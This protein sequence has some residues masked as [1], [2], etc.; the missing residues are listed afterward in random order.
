MPL[1]GGPANK[2]GNRYEAYWTIH[3]LLRVLAGEATS[4]RIEPLGVDKAEFVLTVGETRE[5][6]Q[7]KRSQPD[8]SWTLARLRRAGLLKPVFDLLADSGARF[9]FASGSDAPH[10]REL[11]KAAGRT[12]SQAQFEQYFL[13]AETRSKP[14]Q[15]LLTE[16]QCDAST[17]RDCLQR[18]RVETISEAALREKIA[19]RTQPLFADT[20]VPRIMDALRTIVDDSV[21]ATIDERSLLG[22]LAKRGLSLRPSA[23][24]RTARRSVQAATDRYL[25]DARRKLILGRVLRRPSTLELVDQLQRSEQ[26]SHWTITG[27]AGVGKTA[28]VVDI[29]QQLRESGLSVLAFRMDRIADTSNMSELATYLDLGADSPALALHAAVRGTSRPSVL[30]ID[31]L[32]ALSSASGRTADAFD[33][34]ECLLRE[35]RSL[36]SD[37]HVHTIIVCRE[38]DLAN[39]PALRSLVD[40]SASKLVVE[41][42]EPEEVDGILAKV[43]IEP[44]RLDPR[45]RKLLTMPLNLALFLEITKQGST[46]SRFFTAKELFDKYWNVKRRAVSQRRDV[47]TDQW[48]QAM[49]LLVDL[50][51]TTQRLAVAEAHL[52]KIEPAYLDGLVSEGVLIH[53]QATLSFGHESLL[54]YA[55]ARL[56]VRRS[57]TLAASLKESNQGLFR[58][59]QVR[60]TLSYVRDAD[61]ERYVAELRELL[62][63][64]DVRAHIKD[65]ALSWLADVLDPHDGEWLVWEERIGPILTSYERDVSPE[66]KLARLAW[67]RFL[68]SEQWLAYAD[69]HGLVDRWLGWKNQRVLDDLIP[70]MS[71]DQE[72]FGKRLGALVAEPPDEGREGGLG[73]HGVIALGSEGMNRDTFDGL[74][75]HIDAVEVTDLGGAHGVARLLR[76]FWHMLGGRR[77]EWMAELVAAVV[78]CA[79]RMVRDAEGHEPSSLLLG[80]GLGEHDAVEEAAQSA[81]KAFAQF[82]LPPVLELSELAADGT[83]RPRRDKIWLA[84]PSGESDSLFVTDAVV[85][86]LANALSAWAADEPVPGEILDDLRHRDTGISNHMLLAVYRG[87]PKR[88]SAAAIKTFIEEPWRF[89]CGTISSSRWFARETISAICPHCAPGELKLLEDAISRHVPEWERS[90]TGFRSR[91]RAEFDLLTSIPKGL[92][93]RGAD[94]RIGELERK[95]GEPSDPPMD[96]GGGMV[97]SPIPPAAAD[98]MTD[99]QW[100]RAMN[101]HSRSGQI[102]LGKGGEVKGGARQL[103]SELER[104]TKEDPIRF[105]RLAARLPETAHPAYQLAILRGLATTEQAVPDE[106][107]VAVCRGAYE[108]GREDLQVGCAVADVL[109]GLVDPVTDDTVEMLSWLATRHPHLE[110]PIIREEGKEGGELSADPIHG[111]HMWG[112]NTARGRAAEA[113]AKLILRDAANIGKFESVIDEVLL[114]RHPG[115]VSCF[116]AVIV[117]VSYHEPERGMR[118][119][120]RVQHGEGLVF[121][122][123]HFL[124][125]LQAQLPERFGRVRALVTTMIRS[126]AAHAQRA[127]AQLA[128]LAVLYQ[129]EAGDLVAEAIRGTASHRLGIARVASGNLSGSDYRDWC[130]EHLTILFDD[131]DE[132]VRRRAAS[133]FR[134]LHEHGLETYGE[135]IETFV[136]S[137]AFVEGGAKA[138]LRVLVRS[139]SRLPG[140]TCTVCDRFLDLYGDRA[141]DIRTGSAGAA[142]DAR[143]LVFRTYQQHQ[144]DEWGEKAL[145]LIDRL[146]LDEVWGLKQQFEEFER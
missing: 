6:H 107:K 52:D 68:A 137:R 12:V 120:L 26:A 82:V 60:Q 75:R 28:S 45:Q 80:G 142:M 146:C 121:A 145:D 77:P 25:Q 133:C 94:A 73:P 51:T 140:V 63:D 127:G 46:P 85:T 84:V 106:L 130:E 114:D 83:D 104:H 92:R 115:V 123:P 64:P 66:N 56:S 122:T 132:R 65:L 117:A 9:V 95:F 37:P 59:A 108:N 22:Q 103:S 126:S 55:F 53:D 128:A 62:G 33:L 16:W 113:V 10:L 44:G 39:D 14:F 96:I 24:P 141:G 23:N 118:L 36:P 35:V 8:G 57:T 138:I 20:D 30:V 3:E 47:R 87:D 1:P 29:V 48:L 2:L 4:I 40:S 143:K 27:K 32:D 41:E 124:R 129:N 78:R 135:L 11:A 125:L 61:R 76:T 111:V 134:E 105:A 91:G 97:G 72:R 31:Q 7:A 89:E 18:I 112:I 21:H 49:D 102:R 74:L 119:L 58:R 139:R 116:G 79:I 86:A 101:K 70:A 5:Y 144:G 38:F 90:P 50:M 43:D 71:R 69:E 110:R 93:S 17:A 42:F 15:E 54:D 136:A 100:L 131:A 98:K 109:G 13:E 19:E 67:R 81:P 99:D 88:Y 34:V